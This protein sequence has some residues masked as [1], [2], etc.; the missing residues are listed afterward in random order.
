MSPDASYVGRAFPWSPYQIGREKIREFATAVGE[1]D[2]RCHDV[3]AARAAGH[4][5][6]VAPTTFAATF[7]MPAMNALLCDP[8]FGWDYAR[9]VHGDQSF[10]IRR[11][12]HAGDEVITTL[13]VDDLNTRAGSHRLSLRCE[14]ATVDGDELLT[15]RATLV[16][17]A[18]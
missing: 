18:E 12:V 10:T 3:E 8:E 17:A 16:T 2:P 6:V 5:D 7:T 15:S 1:L 13:Y 14:V 4:P 11:P 9:M